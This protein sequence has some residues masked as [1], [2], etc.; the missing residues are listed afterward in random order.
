MKPKPKPKIKRSGKAYGS[1]D[2]FRYSDGMTPRQKLDHLKAMTL[3]RAM[4]REDEE[5][6][7]RDEAERFAQET[8]ELIQ[9]DLY[10]TIPLALA[11]KLSGRVFTP[12]EVRLIVRAEVD[13][14]VREWVKG[15][16]VSEAAVAT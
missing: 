3:Q 5:W 12:Q 4:K 11:G 15:G 8:A 16:R 6:Q 7:T 2:G 1:L 10:G 9:S 14:A 13:A